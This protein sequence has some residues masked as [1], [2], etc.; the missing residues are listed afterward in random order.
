VWDEDLEKIYASTLKLNRKNVFPSELNW[1][2]AAKANALSHSKPPLYALE[3]Q[4]YPTDLFRF[5]IESGISF[6]FFLERSH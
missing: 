4:T 1:V 3:T 5:L 6:K 2:S